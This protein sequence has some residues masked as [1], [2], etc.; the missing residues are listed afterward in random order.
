VVPLLQTLAPAFLPHATDEMEAAI[1]TMLLPQLRTVVYQKFEEMLGILCLTESPASLL[2]WAHYA[3]AHRGFVVEFDS[4]SPFFNQRLGPED[5][6]RHLRKVSYQ[7]ERPALVLMEIQDFSPF[8][9]KGKDWAYETEWRMMLPLERASRVFGVGP[10]AVHLFDFPTSAIR[11]LILGCRM[12]EAT[13]T[14]IREILKAPEYTHVRCM[15]AR[16]DET[17]YRVVI[18]E[19]KSETVS[20]SET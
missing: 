19:P 20:A 4:E 2:M 1:K 12:P 9:V 16:V 8:L 7:N 15:E 3:D 11:G 6:F 17:R 13:R 14:E 5:D 10:T 18:D